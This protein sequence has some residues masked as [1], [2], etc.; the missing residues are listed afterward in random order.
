MRTITEADFLRWAK[1]NGI[2]PD[3]RYPQSMVLSF[4]PDPQA[5]RFW[6]VPEEP[7][8]RPFFI[9]SL[10]ELMGEWQSCYAWRHSGSWPDSADLGRINDV[11]ELAI[12]R[13][14][15][16]PLGTADVV[17][18]EREEFDKLITLMFSTT[19]FGWSVGEDLYVIPNHGRYILQ[20]DHHDVIHVA[21]R[22]SGA[23]EQWI[24]EM[25]A[26]GFPLPEEVPDATFKKPSWMKESLT[27]CCTASLPGCGCEKVEGPRVGSSR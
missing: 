13:G 20:T 7:E 21:F 5:D 23:V 1:E 19:I 15:G 17:E 16:L 22:E 6:C 4:I 25:T 18:F 2:E 10:L 14:L 26:R 27:T 11:V 3:D 9:A 12:L 24:T 8:R